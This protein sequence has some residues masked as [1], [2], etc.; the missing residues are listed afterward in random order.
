VVSLFGVCQTP[1]QNLLL[2]AAFAARFIP[3]HSPT[4]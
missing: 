3:R 4:F 1:P 2:R